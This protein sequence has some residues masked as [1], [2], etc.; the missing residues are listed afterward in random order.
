MLQEHQESKS[1]WQMEVLLVRTAERLLDTAAGLPCVDGHLP[2]V[3]EPSAQ[4]ACLALR[5]MAPVLAHLHTRAC[6]R[7]RPVGK[8]TH[9]AYELLACML[10]RWGARS[11]VWTDM[12][13]GRC[14]LCCRRKPW[15]ADCC[16]ASMQ[17][18]LLAFT[19]PVLAQGWK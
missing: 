15:P 14:S 16:R 4:Q 3:H 5:N 6:A 2:S 9:C 18:N 1:A 11:D 17:A 12:L 10:G 19:P 7:C 8:W 13:A